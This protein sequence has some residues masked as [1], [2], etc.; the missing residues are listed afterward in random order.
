MDLLSLLKPGNTAATADAITSAVKGDWASV[1]SR[2]GQQAVGTVEIRSQVA[3]PI[4]VDPFAPAPPDVAPNPIMLFVR[5]EFIIRDPQG[6]ETMR[7]APYGSPSQNYFPWLVAGGI[8]L[9][10]G[11]FTVVAAIGAA[12]SRRR[13]RR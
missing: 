7:L 3:P 6:A 9:V 12:L 5:P 4:V 10:V 13:N 11:G 2:L 8:L 1:A